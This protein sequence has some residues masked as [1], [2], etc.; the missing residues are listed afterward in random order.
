[1]VLIFVLISALAFPPWFFGEIHAAS[2]FSFSSATGNTGNRQNIHSSYQHRQPFYNPAFSSEIQQ[3]YDALHSAINC[4]LNL[5]YL[6]LQRIAPT[7][8]PSRRNVVFVVQ[9]M[10][11]LYVMSDNSTKE[12]PIKCPATE[13]FVCK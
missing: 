4:H 7:A 1:V 13:L 9:R 12:L 10:K 6:L 11:N 5:Q 2:A 3:S 8:V